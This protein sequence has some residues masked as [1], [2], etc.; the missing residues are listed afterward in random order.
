MDSEIES[1]EKNGT[2][3]LT[4]LPAGAKKI[5]V[6]WVYKTKLNK[7]GEIEKYK[8]HL[9]AKG[10]VQEYEIDYSEVFAPVARMDT[11]RMILALAAQRSW[12]VYQLDVK[13]TFLQGE[14]A[15]DIYVEQ[16]KGYVQKGAADKVY[17]LKKALYGL[18]QAPRAWFSRI[19]AYF[20]REG[21]E[22]CHSDQTLFIKTNNGGNILIV[23]LY[24]D[25]LI[26]T[27]DNM[28][29]IEEFKKSMMREFEMSNLG[30]MKYFLGI[31]VLQ[32][33]DGIFID[34]KK[35]AMDV[36]KRFGM[37]GSNAVLNPIVPGFKIS[38]DET[39]VEVDA[40]FYKQ[41]VGSLM[42]LT[43]TRPDLMYAVSLI[44]RYMSQ[45]TELHH[46]AA[47]RILRYV[48]GTVNFGILYKKEGNRDLAAFTDS[49]Y[50]GCLEDRKSTSGYAFLLSS[51]AVAWSSKKQP[52]VTLS[53]TEAEFVAAAVCACQA[54][55]MRRILEK[56]GHTQ[57]G[58]TTVMYDNSSTI[59]L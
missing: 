43:A 29:M 34:Q 5:G 12:V 54:V 44:S 42:Y 6:K 16:P 39:G 21:F 59:K 48:Q 20:L 50:A 45:P 57:D 3:I 49:D 14:L 26:Y 53:T 23:S 32:L 25:D 40:T 41:I 1:I 58:C 19:E 8:A 36:L 51:G 31:E 7:H 24:V 30:K 37:E 38:K 22:R 9:V 13:S 27:G 11:V 47:K 10:Y 46:M 52:I 4:D 15:E 35:Y 56:L 2:W 55:W 28:V 17:K 33:S 18:K